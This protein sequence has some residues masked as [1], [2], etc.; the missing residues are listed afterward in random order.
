LP[1]LVGLLA[2]RVGRPVLDRTGLTGKYDFKLE[3]T[4]DPSEL[5]VKGTI[6]K[7]GQTVDGADAGGLQGTSLFAALQEQLGLKLESQKGQVE[8]IVID[9]AE[10]P[11]A[12]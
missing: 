11:A 6:L 8:T 1:L 4:P 10:K 2:R 9:R 7:P 5:M 3:W 12:N